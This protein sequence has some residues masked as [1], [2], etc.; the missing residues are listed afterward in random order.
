[1][2]GIGMSEMLIILAVAL[3]VFGPQKLPEVAKQIAKGLRD[4]RRASDDLRSQVMVD[5]EDEKPRRVPPAEL[6]RPTPAPAL[7]AGPAA[8]SSSAG[9]STVVTALPPTFPG[10]GD[11]SD[12]HESPSGIEGSRLAAPDDDD[13]GVRL[14][15]AEG[16]VGR[17]D[18]EGEGG[19]T[20]RPPPSHEAAATQTSLPVSAPNEPPAEPRRG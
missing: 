17:D 13:D 12:P 1:M 16:I 18:M 3:L 5:L 9:Q 6:M 4:L 14:Q 2:F 7:A 19:R 15:P 20:A 8:S 10:A 11:A